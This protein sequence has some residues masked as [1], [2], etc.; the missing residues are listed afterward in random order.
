MIIGL[1][2]GITGV[3]IL[4]NTCSY[5]VCLYIILGFGIITGILWI[6][7]EGFFVGIILGALNSLIVFLFFM[8]ALDWDLPVISVI[9]STCY[10]WFYGDLFFSP[11]L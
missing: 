5:D 10:F 2:V 7:G 9:I 6:S 11:T 3:I 1:V 8:C 4:E